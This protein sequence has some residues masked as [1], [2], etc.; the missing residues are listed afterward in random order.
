MD[1]SSIIDKAMPKIMARMGELEVNLQLAY[2][3][4]DEQR[5]QIDSLVSELEQLKSKK[6]E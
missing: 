6:K 1:M 5:K 3:Q 4:L 2:A